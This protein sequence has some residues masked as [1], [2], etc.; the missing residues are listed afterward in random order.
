[1]SEE[2][3][4][5]A[6]AGHLPD[7]MK[8]VEERFKCRKCQK[9]IRPPI[10]MCSKGHNFCQIC[11]ALP[12]G[13][14]CPVCHVKVCCEIQNTEMETM[15]EDLKLEMSCK[16]HGAGCDF[17]SA[18]VTAVTAHEEDCPF[19]TVKCVILS[20]YKDIVFSDL[21]EH[22]AKTHEEMLTGDWVIEQNNACG[23]T[24]APIFGLVSNN[25]TY[26]TKT[27]RLSGT[28]FFAFLTAA[29]S[30][31]SVWVMAAC[32]KTA[33]AGFKAEIR[34]AS[35]AMPDCSNVF[36]VPVVHLDSEILRSDWN[37]FFGNRACVK[38]YYRVVGQYCGNGSHLTKDT[39]IPFNCL[40]HKKV[41]LTLDKADI[42]EK[43]EAT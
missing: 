36:F 3:N 18:D 38:V 4:N 21:E 8:A 6:A 19:R 5:A 32:G 34:L 43:E 16:N 9:N 2:S 33:A 28:R 22:M 39:N 31:W 42:E 10:R 11:N 24:Y 15:V 23:P 35:D 7:F 20:C 13:S 1:M 25:W 14:N 17:S 40:V 27:W 41:F 30:V 26:G 37:A 29:H 12:L